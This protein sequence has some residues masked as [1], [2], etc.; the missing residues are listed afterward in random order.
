MN[1]DELF[2]RA[3]P[4]ARVARRKRCKSKVGHSHKILREDT[5]KWFKTKYDATVR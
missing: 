1:T 5:V 2:P 4:G 3:R